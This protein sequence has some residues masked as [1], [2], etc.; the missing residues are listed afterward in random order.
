MN[1]NNAKAAIAAAIKTNHNEEITG[2]VLQSVLLAMVD[3]LGKGYQYKGIA[4]PGT[5]VTATDERAVY[6]AAQAGTY[7]FG[8]GTQQ[9][10]TAGQVAAFTYDSAWHK[11]VIFTVPDAYTK[12]EADALLAGKQ[13][14]LT[15][16]QNISIT[17]QGV[18][19]ATGGGAAPAWGNI[20]GTLS[21]Q[22]DLQNALNALASSIA[23]KYSKP[24]GGI[25]ATDLASAVQTALENIPTM[26]YA[27]D[28][29]ID[30]LF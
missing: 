7:T 25:P 26:V 1:Y 23:A 20:T 5:A 21:D 11:D 13:K 17:E 3:A 16:G 18:I 27:T 19:S 22:T 10:L 2:A 4:V 9:T 8:D 12:S 24:D 15:A 29:E 28:N 30:S 14:T 6:L